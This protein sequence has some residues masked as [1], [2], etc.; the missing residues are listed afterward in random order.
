MTHSMTGILAALLSLSTVVSASDD[1]LSALPGPDADHIRKHL[2]GVVTEYR[3]DAAPIDTPEDWF[4]L[5]T[6]SLVFVDPATGKG[7]QAF[8]L[9]PTVRSKR[10]PVPP[11]DGAWTAS[12]P[13]GVT[14]FIDL[15]GP[16]GLVAPT[17]V[18]ISNG[19]IIRLDPP[20]PLVLEGHEISDPK[21]RTIQVGVYDLH[22]STDE[23]YS[24][25][26]KCTWTDLGAWTVK[27]PHGSHEARLIR[28][29]YNGSIGPA[30]IN[31]RRYTFVAKG[32]GPV[33]YTDM[34]DISAFIFFNDDTGQ[35]GVLKTVSKPAPPAPAKPAG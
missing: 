27:V 6:R 28:I 22:D 9:A 16:D 12:M 20:E 11:R 15:K 23:S 34:R 5:G 21:V 26:V 10:D 24:G 4:P 8:T 17:A 33:A 30:S 35:S 1:P 18:S 31:A 25:S 3:P 19:V 13:G 29:E 7:D 32:I 2:P 14:K